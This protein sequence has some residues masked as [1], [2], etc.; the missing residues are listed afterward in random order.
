MDN[1]S[2]PITEESITVTI[3]EGATWD[4]VS[5]KP[6]AVEENSFIVSNPTPFAWIVKIL[7]QVKT[8]L[9]LNLAVQTIPF[10]IPLAIDVTTYKDWKCTNISGDTT[11]NITGEA[12]GEAGMLEIYNSASAVSTLGTM[13][14][15]NS[16]GGTIDT[17]ASGDNI[18][19]WTKSG[20][21]IIYSIS[22]IE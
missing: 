20:T 4:G 13:F 19:A 5:G 21:D 14:T 12:D 10:A 7:A 11:V 22:Q 6:T 9:G 2:V 15:K 17:A 16:G 1:I 3:S 18:I 8:I